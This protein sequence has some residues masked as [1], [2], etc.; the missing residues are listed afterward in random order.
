V[1]AHGHVSD[2]AAQQRV[3]AA[4][5]AW[6]LI[7]INSPFVRDVLYPAG[8]VR[9]LDAGRFGAR[10][11]GQSA[12]AEFEHWARAADGSTIGVCQRCG[13]FN[14]VVDT[15]A[16]S[17]GAAEDEGFHLAA[18]A[19]NRG[20]Y[21]I[22]AYDDF[23]VLHIA[24]ASGLDPF[25]PLSETEIDT[26]AT[27]AEQWFAGAHLVTRDHRVLNRA[28]LDGSIRFH[29]GGGI[30]TVS[31]A[32][33]DGHTRL[34][35]ITP[36]R[37]PIDGRGGIAFV[38]VNALLAQSENIAEA[39]EFLAFLL[40]PEAAVCAILADGAANPVV[41]MSA[42]DVLTRLDRTIL[43]AMQW[44][45]LESELGRCAQYRVAPDYVRLHAV[46]T[47][48]RVAAGWSCID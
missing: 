25:R 21:G 3:R 37:G 20:R 13:P 7:N 39:E 26:F 1:H 33:R 22:L 47:A 45:T 40:G 24:I 44:D 48:A 38:E 14:L 35:A 36:S 17:V 43:H 29:L 10:N 46:L 18:D 11:P 15:A 4:P 32:R 19:R 8:L 2:F 12:F 31:C 23:N 27:T 9:A 28:L 41:Q 16:I 6:D 42:P 30:Y 5:S 34:R